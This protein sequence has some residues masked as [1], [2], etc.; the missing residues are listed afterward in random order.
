MP[1]S[2]LPLSTCTN[3]PAGLPPDLVAR[4][5]AAGVLPRSGGG[6]TGSIWI[7]GRVFPL[8]VGCWATSEEHRRAHLRPPA[9]SRLGRAVVA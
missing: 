2:S 8:V 1:R 9:R 7:H 5:A 6:H 4:R 3:H